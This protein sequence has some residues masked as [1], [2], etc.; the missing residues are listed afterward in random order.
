MSGS[1]GTYATSGSSD[2]VKTST[3]SSATDDSE[4]SKNITNKN[5]KP[6]ENSLDDLMAAIVGTDAT[7]Y[8]LTQNDTLEKVYEG[9]VDAL[10]VIVGGLT[11]QDG[12]LKVRDDLLTAVVAKKLEEITKY[13]S[14]SA[15]KTVSVSMADVPSVSI[16]KDVI[17]EAVRAALYEGDASKNF[18]SMLKTISDGSLQVKSISDAVMVKNNTG[19][20]LQ[21]SNL[22]W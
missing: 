20:K 2:D 6:P 19:E 5:S 11:M 14:E 3:M 22:V 12:L 13:L 17:I 7:D 10:K 18:S 15:T 21:V 9:S 1:I 16:D 4:E 8:V